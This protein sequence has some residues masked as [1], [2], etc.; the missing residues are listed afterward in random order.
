VDEVRHHARRVRRVRAEVAL[1]WRAE[2]R[3]AAVVARHVHRWNAVPAVRPF[4]QAGLGVVE[5][6]LSKP[7]RQSG[8]LGGL[9]GLAHQRSRVRVPDDCA[10]RAVG[11]EQQGR[12]HGRD[13]VALLSQRDEH[14][15]RCLR[16]AATILRVSPGKHR[17]WPL[18]AAAAPD[19][20]S[21]SCS[22]GLGVGGG[23][24]VSRVAEAT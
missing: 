14:E 18:A 8:R 4:R 9:D 17:C 10:E 22:D 16:A 23:L 1:D 6:E 7:D 15:V 5:R 11:G 2:E 3:H 12:V 24:G 21:C 13:Q 20:L 19:L